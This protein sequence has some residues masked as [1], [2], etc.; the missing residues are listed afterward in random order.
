MLG[1]VQGKAALTG[2]TDVSFRLPF[3]LIKNFP[4]GI[5]AYEATSTQ[6]AL[7]CSLHKGV[8]FFFYF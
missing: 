3:A 1:T 2:A 8:N 4:Q 5:L 7:L 6:L